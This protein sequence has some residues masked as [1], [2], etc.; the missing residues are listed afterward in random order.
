MGRSNRQAFPPSTARTVLRA[1]CAIW[2]GT[3][4]SSTLR[5]PAGSHGMMQV[6]EPFPFIARHGVW[7]DEQRRQAEPL[8]PRP[9]KRTPHLFHLPFPNPP[10]PPPPQ[11]S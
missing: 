3:A 9:D 11:A 5:P 4:P 10:A 2:I 6:K 7:T 8:N 1:A